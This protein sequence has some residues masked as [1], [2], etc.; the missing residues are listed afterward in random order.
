MLNT[1][2]TL[3]AVTRKQQDDKN[4]EISLNCA[5]FPN[6]RE[7]QSLKISDPNRFWYIMNGFLGN[8]RQNL[9]E[10]VEDINS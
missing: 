3:F 5:N 1:N 7:H 10:L 6:H 2:L 9:S 8:S 4:A